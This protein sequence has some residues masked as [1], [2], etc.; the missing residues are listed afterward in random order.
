MVNEQ[1]LMTLYGSKHLE[2]NF[3]FCLF[4]QTT[5]HEYHGVLGDLENP[6]RSID[7]KFSM[8]RYTVQVLL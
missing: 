2:Q 8:Y 1:L 4:S 5:V 7:T 3:F 6:A